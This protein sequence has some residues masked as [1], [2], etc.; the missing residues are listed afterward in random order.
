M[1]TVELLGT[2]FISSPMEAFVQELNRRL[3]S[4]QQTFVV[5]ANPEIMMYTYKDPNYAQ[6]LKH[7]DYIIPDGI[8]V[9]M[10]S[11]ILKKP[12]ESRLPGFDLMMHLLELATEKNY[13]VYFLGAKEEVIVKAVKQAAI[14]FPKLKI[15]GYHHGYIDFNDTSIIEE[16]RSKSPDIV[17]V[18]LGFP[19][20]EMWIQ[21][22][23]HVMEKGVFMGVGGSFDV[24]AG[25]VKRAPEIWQ[26]LNLEWLYRLIKQPSRWRRMTVLPLYLLKAIKARLKR[27]N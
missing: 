4:G 27:E 25:L 26:K 9:V 17:L 2:K 18:G 15:A 20:Q 10:A 23:R 12:I 8:G 24:L 14:Q 11:K 7:A 16:I 5:T 22:N 6:V 13:S 21:N 19:Q 3:I 1:K